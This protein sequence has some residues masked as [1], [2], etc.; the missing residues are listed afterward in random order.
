MYDIEYTVMNFQQYKCDYIMSL[1]CGDVITTIG[2]GELDATWSTS[3][4][5]TENVTVKIVGDCD[6]M[7]LMV[8]S[9]R[10]EE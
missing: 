7:H 10:V 9:A 6:Q 1:V 2:S 4:K 5:K 8:L 3:G